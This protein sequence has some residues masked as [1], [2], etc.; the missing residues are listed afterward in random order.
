MWRREEALAE[1]S[2]AMFLD[3][4]ASAESAAHVDPNRRQTSFKE[5]IQAQVLNLKVRSAQEIAA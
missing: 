1:V 3:L 2:A 5:Q 4:P